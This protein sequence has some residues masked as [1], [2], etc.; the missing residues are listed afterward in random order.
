MTLIM[1]SKS[2]SIVRPCREVKLSAFPVYGY[3]GY[4]V[5]KLSRN[6]LS[7]SDVGRETWRRYFGEDNRVFKR[8]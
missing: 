8:P 2:M 6:P 7:G 3:M 1:H 5:R 4:E